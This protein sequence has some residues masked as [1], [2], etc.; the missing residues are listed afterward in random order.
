M[1]AVTDDGLIFC[2]DCRPSS[3]FAVLGYTGKIYITTSE[4]NTCTSLVYNIYTHQYNIS[5][6]TNLIKNGILCTI[7][8]KNAGLKITGF[9]Y[10]STTVIRLI[11]RVLILIP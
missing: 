7:L 2:Q 5:L 3:Q 4:C 9:Y 8:H 6:Y 10:T 1:T 11:V